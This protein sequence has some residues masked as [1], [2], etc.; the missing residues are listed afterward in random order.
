[1]FPFYLLLSCTLLTTAS[2]VRL[3]RRKRFCLIKPSVLFIC[4][5][6]VFLQWPSVVYFGEVR[7][8]LSATLLD[9]V[10]IFSLTPL[11]V[12]FV[13]SRLFLRSARALY[14]RL[15]R[16]APIRPEAKSIIL[17][18]A[19]AGLA[20]YLLYVPLGNTGLISI[21]RGDDQLTNTLI[22]EESMK[23]LPAFLRYAYIFSAKVLCLMLIL[24]TVN[25]YF[26]ARPSGGKRLSALWQLAVLVPFGLGFNGISGARST[27]ADVF[28]AI[29]LFLL[30]RNKLRLSFPAVQKAVLLFLCILAVPTVLQYLRSD[31]KSWLDALGN[32]FNRAFFIKLQAGLNNIHYAEIYGYWGIGAIPKLGQLF[33]VPALN[34]PNII[35][36]LVYPTSIIKTGY[37]NASFMM[38]YYSY[39]GMIAFPLCIVL[40]LSLDVIPW[41]VRKL[42]QPDLYSYAA[43]GYALPMYVLTSLD[44]TSIFIGGG[45]VFWLLLLSLVPKWSVKTLGE[46]QVA[47]PGR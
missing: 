7:R 13:A 6:H 25:D 22:R 24:V 17:L 1:M 38:T 18:G 34:V 27:G 39:F 32:I 15:D 40:I 30:F 4:F 10:L 45:V 19:L 46:P 33:G 23:L 26:V 16:P 8:L 9:F 44:Y 21:L 11:I 5:F 43:V 20:L 42:I 31:T 41:L 47:V 2:L 36:N 29:M 14:A 12:L 28:I 35:A 37:V 3:Y